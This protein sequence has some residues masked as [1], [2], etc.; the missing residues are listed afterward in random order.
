VYPSIFEQL[1]FPCLDVIDQFGIEEQATNQQ[2]GKY[3]PQ[4]G[5][6]QAG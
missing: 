5:Q 3:D 6:Q 2:I 4:A 1:P